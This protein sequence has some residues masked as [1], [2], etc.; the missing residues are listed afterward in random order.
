[1]IGMIV[2]VSFV[3]GVTVGII[4]TIFMSFSKNNTSN[5]SDDQIRK[6]YLEIVSTIE[7][8]LFQED[9]DYYQ[10]LMDANSIVIRT[11]H[12]HLGYSEIRDIEIKEKGE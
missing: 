7:K 2:I 10:G 8:E 1:M 3:L 5:E 6:I 12:K 4:L 11:F 9:G